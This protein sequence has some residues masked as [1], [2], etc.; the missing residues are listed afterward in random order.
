MNY[1]FDVIVISHNRQDLTMG[2]LNNLYSHTS[3]PF[4]LIVI[5][6]SEDLTPMYLEKVKQER[7]NITVIHSDIPYKSGNQIFNIGFTN[8]KTPYVATVMN[9]VNVEPDWDV[10][11]MNILEAEPKVGLIGFKCLFP[12]G[13]IESAGVKM[14]KW[15]PTDIGRDEPGHRMSMVYD[16]E[17]I[18]W[19]FALMRK[20]AVAP[21]EEDIFHGFAGWDDIDNSFVVKKR[22]W[23]ILY[24][25]LGVGYHT[26]RATRGSEELEVTRKNQE[27]GEIFY[28]RWGLWDEYLST[29]IEENIHKTEAL[30]EIYA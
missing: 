1:K 18:Q 6:D 4:H 20:E 22:G 26:P 12:N 28:K 13:L 14:N 21:L 8:M 30:K 5:D 29:P 15:L 9:S 23:E 16:V 10:V 2:C 27:N 11:G 3:N 24:C 7:K 17:A 25:G 19:A